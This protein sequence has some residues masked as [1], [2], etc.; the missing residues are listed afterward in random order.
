MYP[1]S[2]ENQKNVKKRKK[3]SHQPNGPTLP[4]IETLHHV[5]NNNY[6]LEEPP[7][8]EYIPSTFSAPNYVLFVKALEQ[9]FPKVKRPKN[10]GKNFPL[11]V[12]G[13]AYLSTYVLEYVRSHRPLDV[14]TNDVVD[15]CWKCTVSDTNN[16]RGI[17]AIKLPAFIKH[18]LQEEK[19]LEWDINKNIPFIWLVCWLNNIHPDQKRKNWQLHIIKRTC[20]DNSCT[21]PRHMRWGRPVV[22]PRKYPKYWTNDPIGWRSGK[23]PNDIKLGP[24]FVTEL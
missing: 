19:D 20:G 12:E 22:T 21:N 2:Y 4:K 5:Y 18:A 8:A 3:L 23:N 24:L 16:N 9:I 11:A 15:K 17:F 6:S 14:R 10:A 1:E 7:E 13:Y